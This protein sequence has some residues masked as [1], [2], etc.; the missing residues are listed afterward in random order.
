MRKQFKQVATLLAALILTGAVQAADKT[1]TL[2]SEGYYPPFNFFNSAGQL[3][4]LD[5]DLGNALC[6]QL[7]AKCNWVATDWDGIIPALNAKK[8][9]AI[10]ASMS[11]NEKRKKVVS[12]TDPYYFNGI[13]FI[14][15][16]DNVTA[17]VTPKSM[18]GKIIGTQS[19]TGEVEILKQYFPDSELK[20][21]PKL[22]DSLLDLNSGRVDYVIASQ[23][24]LSEW[25]EKD[26]GQ[27]CQFTGPAF[28]PDGVAGTGIAVRKSD[29]ALLDQLNGALSAI[30]K[31]G[32]YD[33]IRS[34]YFSV[35]I[36]NRPEN[37]SVLFNSQ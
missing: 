35:D 25:L 11:I 26:E 31:N 30:I 14:S 15:A 13:R 7:K 4:G 16:K 5:I 27:C 34:Q 6:E 28:I 21:Y 12:F 3:Q 2:G 19:G 32:T 17:E 33:K 1:I 37:A 8:F 36:T 22:D 18:A 23:F 24:V 29:T 20:L 10:I 9:D